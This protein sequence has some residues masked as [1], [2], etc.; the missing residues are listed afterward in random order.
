MTVSPDQLIERSERIVL[1]RFAPMSAGDETEKA[2]SELDRENEIE[3][4]VEQRRN[5][6]IDRIIAPV[7]IGRFYVKED[8]KGGGEAT[9]YAPV[10]VHTDERA[11]FDFSDH[12]DPAFWDSPAAGRIM[13]TADCRL[14]PSFAE[15]ETYLLFIGPQHVKSYEVIRAD[16]DK[17]LAYV[18]SQL[19]E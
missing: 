16:D 18:K 9:I 8:L 2:D 1:A 19:T 13:P 7:G 4:A 17:W 5:R 12:K 14:V 3:K 6:D 10:S 15:D 11:T